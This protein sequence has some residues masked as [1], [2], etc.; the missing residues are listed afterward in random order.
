MK[1]SM[2]AV[3]A[4]VVLA[5]CSTSTPVNV[6]VPEVSHQ[7]A[8]NQALQSQREAAG[9]PD[10]PTSDLKATAKANGLPAVTLDCLGSTSQVNLAGLA[11]GKPMLINFWAQWCDGCRVEGPTL[12]QTYA[13]A[14]ASGKLAMLGVLEVD[15]L[16]DAAIDLAKA[17]GTTYPMVVDPMGELRVPLKV[18]ALPQTLFIDAKGTIVHRE[19]GAIASQARMAQLLK[20]YLGVT[21]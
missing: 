21:L 20:Q 3:V 10:C 12:G 8:Q 19:L 15:P 18:T 7:Q 1:R 14:K 6:T 11:L 16:P 17:D 13:K 2:S 5:G 9:I 4:A